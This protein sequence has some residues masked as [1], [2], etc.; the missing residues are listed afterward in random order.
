MHFNA[1][2]GEGGVLARSLGSNLKN[3][4][5]VPSAGQPCLG[6]GRRKGRSTSNDFCLR[7]CCRKGRAQHGRLGGEGRAERRRRGGGKGRAVA[8]GFGQR[9]GNSRCVP[10]LYGHRCSIGKRRSRHGGSCRVRSSAGI[11]QRNVNWL[12]ERAAGFGEGTSNAQSLG[13]RLGDSYGVRRAGSRARVDKRSD[14]SFFLCCR[15]YF[16]AD[17]CHFR[18]LTRRISCSRGGG[19]SGVVVRANTAQQD[20][21]QIERGCLRVAA[22]TD[23]NSLDR[24]GLGLCACRCRCRCLGSGLGSPS[25]CLCTRLGGCLSCALEEASIYRGKS[26]SV[27][28][29]ASKKLGR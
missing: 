20:C 25:R 8:H 6:F 22:T 14:H 17:V 18:A 24:D 5:F 9:S 29:M 27:V 19:K 4:T 11:C 7:P 15:V 28:S 10:F 1:F 12:Q 26:G 16:I 13:D 3:K 23:S 2:G 21:L